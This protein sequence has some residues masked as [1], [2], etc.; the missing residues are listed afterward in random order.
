MRT[1]AT[2]RATHAP[3]VLGDVGQH[4]SD[5]SL[6]QHFSDVSMCHRLSDVSLGQRLSDVSLRQHLSDV[7]LCQRLNDVSMCQYLSDVSFCRT[8]PLV[9]CHCVGQ[10]RSYASRL[11]GVTVKKYGFAMKSFC[12]HRQ[13]GRRTRSPFSDSTER[14]RNAEDRLWQQRKDDKFMFSVGAV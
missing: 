9:T 2:A 3:S 13:A 4:L 12:C 11:A 6:R 8:A 1:R 14:H 7:S 5:V 10:H